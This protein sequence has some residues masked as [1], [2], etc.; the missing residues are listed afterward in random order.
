M[1]FVLADLT[2]NVQ[3]DQN[4]DHAVYDVLCLSE[5]KDVGKVFGYIMKSG[6]H[7]HMFS[8]I[9]QFATCYNAL[10]LKKGRRR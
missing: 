1:D 6:E 8:S 7:Q 10:A 9:L 3:R 2:Y 4:D 5:I